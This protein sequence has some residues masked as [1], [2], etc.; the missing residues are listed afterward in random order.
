MLLPLELP[1]VFF[2]GHP[3]EAIKRQSKR[4]VTNAFFR[5]PSFLPN[6]DQNFTVIFLW[7]SCPVK[8]YLI[9]LPSLL[10][11]VKDKCFY[12]FK[13]RIIFTPDDHY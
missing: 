13:E 5:L 8:Q 12:P 1:P 7:L 11:M 3:L 9:T 2:R 6:P 10:R 4:I